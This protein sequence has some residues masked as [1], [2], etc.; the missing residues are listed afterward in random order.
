MPTPTTHGQTVTRLDEEDRTPLLPA[1]K[2]NYGKMAY[3]LVRAGAD[4]NTPYVDE[5]GESHNLLMDSIII[6]NADFALLLIEHGA[7][8]YYMDDHKVTTL[9][10]AT[11]HGIANVANALPSR[12][13]I[14][15]EDGE[16][17]L[18]RQRKRE[19]RAPGKART[20]PCGR[21]NNP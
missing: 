6:E 4:P 10:Q 3:T 15:T 17:E 18:G 8:V 7:D 12:H 11:H 14:A 19:G 21:W 5:D 1:F 13:T 16:G 9:P 20:G 2:G